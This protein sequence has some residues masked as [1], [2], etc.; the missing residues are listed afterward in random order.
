MYVQCSYMTLTG[1][2]AG[3]HGQIHPN[4]DHVAILL[5]HDP[6]SSL[7]YHN[8]MITRIPLVADSLPV[9]MASKCSYMYM[10]IIHYVHVAVGVPVQSCIY[11]VHLCYP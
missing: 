2:R 7:A 4:Y 9:V 8:I 3:V 11:V 10:Y 6:L 5:A 1:P